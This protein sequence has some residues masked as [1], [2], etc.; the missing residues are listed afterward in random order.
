MIDSL[1]VAQQQ[2]CFSFCR[3]KALPKDYCVGRKAG[4]VFHSYFAVR[5]TSH[6]AKMEVGTLVF[7]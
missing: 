5:P 1:T 4:A 2:G 6:K 3:G 7:R